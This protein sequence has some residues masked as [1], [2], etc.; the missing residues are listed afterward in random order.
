M[1]VCVIDNIKWLCLDT[2]IIYTN[3]FRTNKRQSILN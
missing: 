2:F 1:E 3:F